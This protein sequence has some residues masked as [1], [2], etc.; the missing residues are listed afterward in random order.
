MKNQLIALGLATLVTGV[1][2]TPSLAQVVIHEDR[3]SPS[4]YVEEDGDETQFIQE[5]NRRH[6]SRDRWSENRRSF[7]PRDVIRLLKR[8]G[9]RVR[10]VSDVGERYLVKASRDGDDLLVSVSR[11]GEIMGVIHDHY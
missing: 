5:F 6:E 9:Y 7:G 3:R 8:R 10:D 4:V 2:T 11:S 1:A